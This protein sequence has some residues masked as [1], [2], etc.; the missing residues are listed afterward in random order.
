SADD[1]M[2]I[3]FTSGTTGIPKGVLSSHRQSL[4]VARAWAR[5]AHLSPA[6]RYAV[7]NPFFHGFGYKAGMITSLMAGATIYPVAVFSVDQLLQLVQDAGITVLPG[8][9]TIF[10]SMLDHPRLADYDLSSL[11]F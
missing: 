9:P 11:R 7:V 8:V 5:G 1:I 3:L 10:T 4:G 6:D 2:D